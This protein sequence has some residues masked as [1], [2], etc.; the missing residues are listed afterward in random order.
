V[1]ER[2]T[3]SAAACPSDALTA[4]GSVCRPAVGACDLAERCSGSSVS[5]PGNAHKPDLSLC[6]GGLLGLPGVCLAGVC[7]L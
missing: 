5:C 2:C 7:V 6:S 1:A 3:G 4:A